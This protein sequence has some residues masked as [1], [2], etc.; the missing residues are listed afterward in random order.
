[1]SAKVQKSEQEWREQLTPEQFD[2]TRKG[3]TERAFT[4]PYVDEKS[5]GMTI[6]RVWISNGMSFKSS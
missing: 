1:M 6:V 3:G 2:V 4:G 5:E